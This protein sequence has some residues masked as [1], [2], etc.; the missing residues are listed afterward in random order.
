M[1]REFVYVGDPMCAWC[2]GFAPVL[3]ELRARFDLPVQLILGGLHVGDEARLVD[4]AMAVELEKHFAEVEKT[5]AQPITKQIL[6]NRGWWY[7]TGPACAAVVAM[8]TQAP[9]RALP[10]FEHL[11]RAFFQGGIDLADPNVYPMLIKGHAVDEDRFLRDLRSPEVEALTGEDLAIAQSLEVTGF[12]TLFLRD[13]DAWLLISRG[14]APL[15]VLEPALRRWMAE[16]P[17]G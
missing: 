1:S 15:I 11:Q 9:E 4:D 17:G 12:P 6:E 3:E 7:D 5:T 14:Y 2:W 10:F 8:R 13:G 16:N